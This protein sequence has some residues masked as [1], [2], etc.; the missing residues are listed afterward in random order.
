MIHTMFV[1]T[2]CAS[3][4]QD[5]KTVGVSGG[6]KLYDAVYA[7]W[8]TLPSQQKSLIDL[9]PVA[10]M[11]ACDRPSVVSFSATG[12]HTYLFGDLNPEKAAALLECMRLY[13]QRSDG[14]LGWSERPAA[15]K[16][17]V[18]ARIPPLPALQTC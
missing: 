3:T 13:Q 7:L 17:G 6:Q 14:L 5:G 9:Q 15:L 10:C 18:L 11:S 1:C 8:Q 16:K 4:W 12:K 2:T